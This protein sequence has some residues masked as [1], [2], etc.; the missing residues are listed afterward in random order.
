MS[1]YKATETFKDLGIENSYQGLN[2]DIFFALKRGESVEIKQPPDH[3]I[4]GDYIKK[5]RGI[6][7]GS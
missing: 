6:K 7:D 4:E 3:L 1:K 2:T 5:I